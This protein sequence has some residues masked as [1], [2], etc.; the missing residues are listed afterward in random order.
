MKKSLFVCVVLTLLLCFSCGVAADAAI[1][2]YGTTRDCN[3]SVYVA[4]PDGGVNLREAPTTD[5]YIITTIPDFV[6][7]QITMES[8]N[9]NGWGYT[10]YNGDYGWVALSQ[11]SQTFPVKQTSYDV[12]ITGSSVNHREGPYTSYY[13]YGTI[14]YGTKVHIEAT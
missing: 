1:Y 11:V 14:P 5:A 10:C 3:Y 13:S 12:V 4:T 7:L 9:G 8:T 6:Q 2:D